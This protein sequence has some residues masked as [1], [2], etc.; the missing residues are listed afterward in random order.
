MSKRFFAFSS[1][2]T[3][4][5]LNLASSIPVA[6]QLRPIEPIQPIQTRSTQVDASAIR[7]NKR[8]PVQFQA[9][10][11]K[12]PETGAPISA[13]TMLTLPEGKT[14]SAGEYY[15]ELNRFEQEFSQ[16]GYSLRQPEEKVLLQDSMIDQSALKVQVDGL[17]SAHHKI[18][19]AQTLLN[20]SLDPQQ[21]LKH[22]QEP[23]TLQVKP[24]ALQQ[25]QVAPQLIDLQ[26]APGLQVNLGLQLQSRALQDVRVNPGLIKITPIDTPIEAIPLPKIK[27]PVKA[28]TYTHS[29]GTSIG[30]Q[31]T[32]AAYINTKLQMTA[33]P[34]Y[35][36][37]YAEGNAGG[38]AFNNQVNLLRATA[39]VNA[40][41][42]GNAN[43]SLQL[44][45]LGQT[46]YNFQDSKNALIVKGDS[47]SKS[48]DRTI[49][50]VRFSVGPIP[51][52]ATFG[53]QGSAGIS[54]FAV[55][56]PSGGNVYAK[57]NPFI[58]SKAYG[59]GGADIVV[60]GAG[61]GANLTLLKDDLDIR[62]AAMVRLDGSNKPYLTAQLSAYNELTALS[63]NAY[64]YAYVYVPRFGI[65]P[66]KK[67][68][69]DWNIFS[70]SGL[71][72]NGYL[73]DTSY[74]SYF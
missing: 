58:D 24:G 38:Y 55:A 3:L 67:K 2:L 48:Y 32:F 30:S 46:V 29:W 35:S 54:Y 74:T 1:L 43:L 44:N 19:P 56:N 68:Q 33:H 17:E 8:S 45:A 64:A 69:W 52:R 25:L 22:L 14:I 9:F 31:S 41:K 62:G 28:K 61:V 40:Q 60:G 72:T 37:A 23:A 36:S 34:A 47:F 42:S 50:D 26:V 18:A 21:A 10:E 57:V 20:T 39:S 6:A 73:F 5:T 11:L 70:W 12:H 65:P 49:A 63:G 4:S 7:L 16:L 27:I 66:W 71:K 59:Q 53:V 15:A 13:D 51:M